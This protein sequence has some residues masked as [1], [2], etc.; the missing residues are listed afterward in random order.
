MAN[1][2]QAQCDNLTALSSEKRYESDGK[3][4][5]YFVDRASDENGNYYEWKDTTSAAGSTDA[6]RKTAAHT[7]LKA[8]CEFKAAPV[9]KQD[10]EKDLLV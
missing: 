4:F 2:T 6:T 5:K 10:K 1:F 8:N 9:S 3:T 7:Y